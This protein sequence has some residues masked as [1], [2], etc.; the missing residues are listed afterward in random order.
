MYEYPFP[1]V[2][3]TATLL[4]I[5]KDQ[6][7]L[8]RRTESRE[9][10]EKVYAGFL[11]LPGGFL[12]AGQE[13]VEETAI[14]E[15]FEETSIE[16]EFPDLHLFHVSSDPKTDP[17]AHVINTC[18]WVELMDEDVENAKAGDDLSELI[19]TPF[20]TLLN[21]QVTLAFDHIEI[22]KIGIK[23]YQRFKCSET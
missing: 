4:L 11:S 19:L 8:G 13:I 14:R 17:R 12:N 21:D 20:E 6:V 5:Y 23:H 7:L 3:A 15:C 1:M 18:Y 2:S 22:A 9:K 10:K 16:L